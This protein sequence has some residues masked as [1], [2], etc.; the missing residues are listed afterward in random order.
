MLALF[1]EGLETAFFPC[2]LVLAVPSVAVA[3]GGRRYSAAGIGTFIVGLIISSWLR[4]AGLSEVWPSFI[5][6]VALLAAAALLVRPLVKTEVVSAAA[7]G[8]VA[9]AATG[10]LWR[11]C[12]GLEFGE[13]LTAMDTS[14]PA[15]VVQLM[16]YVIGVMAPIIALTAVANVVPPRWIEKAK[17][18]LLIIGAGVL[19][20]LGAAVIAGLDDRV[21]NR[22]FELSSF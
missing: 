2:S 15:G 14:G 17:R 20:I 10:S 12:V 16:I 22:L 4:F 6:G 9:G 11:P 8:L 7:A 18:P 21:I 19:V 3:L 13:V 5:T 1:A